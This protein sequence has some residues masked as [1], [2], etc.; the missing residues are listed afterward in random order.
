MC[1][2]HKEDALIGIFKKLGINGDIDPLESKEDFLK[3]KIVEVYEKMSVL[4]IW[5]KEGG[6]K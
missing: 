6:L 5:G 2:Q 3:R 4:I 1:E